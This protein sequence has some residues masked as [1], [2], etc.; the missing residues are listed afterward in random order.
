V[1]AYLSDVNLRAVLSV[2][3]SRSGGVVEVTNAEIYDC[4]LPGNGRTERFRVE[5]TDVGLR[6]S[7]VSDEDEQGGKQ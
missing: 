7:L 2:L 4:M 5:E 1:R 6:L 3:I